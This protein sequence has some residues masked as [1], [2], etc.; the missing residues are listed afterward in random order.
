MVHALAES[1]GYATHSLRRWYLDVLGLLLRSI[2]RAVAVKSGFPSLSAI[3][4]SMNIRT[5]GGAAFLSC[6]QP[7]KK[8]IKEK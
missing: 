5:D 3:L 6:R 1:Y 8:N 2:I 4:K 7:A